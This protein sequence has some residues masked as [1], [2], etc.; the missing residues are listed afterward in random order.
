[1][2]LLKSMCISSWRQY[3]DVNIDFHPRLTIITGANGAGKTTILDIINLHFGWQKNIVATAEQ[4]E[5]DGTIKFLS[6]YFGDGSNT[7]FI[8]NMAVTRESSHFKIGHIEYANGGKTNIIIPKAINSQ[9]R[10]SIVNMPHLSGFNIAS[11]RP[12]YKYQAVPQ[13]S[14]TIVTKTAIFQNYRNLQINRI[15]GDN[16]RTDKNENYHIKQTLISL[17]LLGYGNH[18]VKANKEAIKLYEGFIQILKDVLPP[19][20]GFKSI[21]IRIPEVIFETESGD[22]SIDAVSGG[23]ASIIDLAW[24]IYMYD[25]ERPFIVV[26][27]EPENHLHPE[28]Q[29]TILPNF[30]KVFPNVQFIVAT[31]N[32]FIISSV[33]DSNIY[34]LLYDGNNKVYSQLLQDIEKSGTANQILREVLGIESTTPD[35]VNEKLNSVIKKYL[36]NSLTAENIDNFKQDLREIGLEKYITQS[37]FDLIDR[38]KHE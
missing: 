26:F 2:L 7:E 27:D 14:T 20:L 31:H 4:D 8:Q 13:I 30:L 34:A 24:Q 25:N 32:P 1:M 17:S 12:V 15:I 3:K 38:T 16:N 37:V 21:S 11:H 19:K 5:N 6:G 33:Q 10:V 22:F 23:V 9:Y 36:E 35:W 18:K 29:K 28:M